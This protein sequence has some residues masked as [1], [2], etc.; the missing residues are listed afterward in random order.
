VAV[1]PPLDPRIVGPAEKLVA[2]YYPGVPL[3]PTMS[4]GATDAIFLSKIGIPTY[5]VPGTYSD[6]EGSGAHG[7]NERMSV[8]AL[9]TGRDLLTDLVKDLAGGK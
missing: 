7:L 2:K 1:L 5:G 4:T 6:P 9:L 8:K 3:V